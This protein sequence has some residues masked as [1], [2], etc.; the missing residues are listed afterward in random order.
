MARIFVISVL[1][2]MLSPPFVAAGEEEKGVDY[3]FDYVSVNGTVNGHKAL[4]NLTGDFY[5]TEGGVILMKIIGPPSNLGI[6]TLEIDSQPVQIFFASEFYYFQMNLTQGHHQIYLEF[7]TKLKDSIQRGLDYILFGPALRYSVEFAIP[8]PDAAVINLIDPAGA[9]VTEDGDGITLSWD[10]YGIEE[11]RVNPT[12]SEQKRFTAYDLE[13]SMLT[14]I[15][16]SVA[17]TS[18]ITY[19][20]LEFHS[21]K[22]DNITIL[23]PHFEGE[24]IRE[25]SMVTTDYSGPPY[26]EIED[27][28]WNP[29][30]GTMYLDLSR[31]PKGERMLLLKQRTTRENVTVGHLTIPESDSTIA[32]LA[33]HADPGMKAEI[34]ESDNL[35]RAAIAD[36]ES[37]LVE[38]SGLGSEYEVFV[39]HD[40]PLLK[41]R[42]TKIISHSCT[43]FQRIW[44]SSEEIELEETIDFE[45]L[46]HPINVIFIPVFEE[47]TVT[48]VT[49]VDEWH[50]ENGL[51]QLVFHLGLGGTDRVV[52]A[53]EVPSRNRT[54]APLVPLNI[55]VTGIYTVVGGDDAIHLGIS[56]ENAT[57]LKYDSLPRDYRAL[58]RSPR[59][60]FIYSSDGDPSFHVN[61]SA[62]STQDM[63]STII[64]YAQ[65]TLII[66]RD[67]KLFAKVVYLLKNKDQQ[68]MEV[69]LP[70]NTEIWYVLVG[71]T[72]TDIFFENGTLI[73]PLIRST[74][75]GRNIAYPVEIIYVVPVRNMEMIYYLPTSN[76]PVILTE[77]NMGLP[78]SYTV[79]K[80]QETNPN[81]EFVG[82]FEWRNV[83]IAMSEETLYDREYYDKL[84]GAVTQISNM[85][86]AQERGSVS[87]LD[88]DSDINTT[89]LIIS[90]NEGNGYTEEDINDNDIVEYTTYSD[91]SG[92]SIEMDPGQYRFEYEGISR[93][94]TVLPGTEN[95]LVI[96]S[97]EGISMTPPPLVIDLPESGKILRFRKIYTTPEEELNLTVNQKVVSAE[98]RLVP[99]VIEDNPLVFSAI[100]GACIAAAL[101]ALVLRRRTA[102]DDPV[103]MDLRTFVTDHE[104]GVVGELYEPDDLIEGGEVTEGAK[105]NSPGS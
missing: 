92:C 71:G 31:V 7:E 51:I 56:A 60:V 1:V 10:Y 21:S 33:Y 88:L 12:W 20:H 15:T 93:T 77:V 55:N 34:M 14:V 103:N 39:A 16:S 96:D 62:Y 85:G 32:Y 101:L 98:F 65:Y 25:P 61:I 13:T 6:I 30:T 37:V 44:V 58:V 70:E 36:I 42:V 74:L 73:I 89:L 95:Q 80:V 78:S 11:Q 48:G 84:E 104:D 23:F 81:F 54:L 27:Y 105:K 38:V 68:R 87:I 5:V 83:V 29:D 59:A 76:I 53:G 8:K 24:T 17:E 72:V 43:I 40:T 99:E 9:T 3:I 19:L 22:F 35:T 86:K 57:S 69:S 67:R 45:A 46:Y 94:M 100:G 102:S 26:L 41:L 52:I 79:E 49:G 4:F 47:L 64:E 2:L 97:G 28:A 50:V 91:N 63:Q 75:T 66:T 90:R 82:E 18:I